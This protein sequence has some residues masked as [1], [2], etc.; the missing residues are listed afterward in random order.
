MGVA[1]GKAVWLLKSEG[2]QVWSWVLG[3]F[4]VA[5][6]LGLIITQ[7]GPIIANHINL[8]ATAKDAADEAA[9]V[10]EKTHGNMNEV[11]KRVSKYLEDHSARLAG[12][13]TVD[14]KNPQ[15]P[16]IQVPVRKIVNT[17]LFEHVSYLAG[18]TEAFAEGKANVYK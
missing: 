18:Y 6:V 3:I 12:D 5:L 16:T 10:Y 8:G 7:C 4:L 13:I 2:G 15:N 14:N 17:A 9:S 11:Q 1:M